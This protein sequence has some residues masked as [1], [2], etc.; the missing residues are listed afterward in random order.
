MQSLS[1]GCLT[2]PC[3]S[4]THRPNPCSTFISH[5]PVIDSQSLTF[6]YLYLRLRGISLFDLLYV[7]QSS[8]TQFKTTVSEG[9]GKVWE[10]VRKQKDEMMAKLGM[11][12]RK[13]EQMIESQAQMD[14][15]L[16]QVC[17]LFREIE[18]LTVIVIV[19]HVIS[20]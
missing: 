17:F 12:G 6:L 15:R 4:L 7:S 2:A 13:Q 14:E 5:L 20:M 18:C 3:R 16:K 9:F 19:F 1:Y 10:E 8:L 11:V